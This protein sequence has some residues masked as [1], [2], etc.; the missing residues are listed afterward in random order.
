MRYGRPVRL[1]LDG[2]RR[3]VWTTA[4]TVQ[5]ALEELG[6]RAEGAYVSTSRSRRIG[7]EG[8]ALDVRTERTVTVMADGRARTVRTN[9]A[10]VRGGRRAGRDHAAAAGHH[11]GPGGQFPARRADR[12]GAADHRRRRKSARSR[13][14]SE[15]RAD[16]GPLRVQGHGGRR[17][18]GS[19]R[20]AADHV[21]PAHRQ[22]RQAEAAADQD[23]G[24]ARA[25][26]ADREGRHQADAHLRAGRRPAGL[27]GPRG[28]RVRRAAERAWTPRG[29]TAG[30]TSS[31]PGPGRASAARAAPR[32]HRRRNRRSGRRS[33]T[34][35]AG[36]ARGRTAGPGCTDEASTRTAVRCPREQPLPR[37]PP[38]P[39]RHPRTRGRPRRTPHQAAR[40]ELRDRREHGPPDRPHRRVRPDD[41][42]VEV[43]PA[44]ARSPSPC[45]RR[46]TAS[47]P[48]R[49]TTSWRPRCPPP[50]PRAC[51]TAPDRFALV[52]SRRHAGHRAAGPRARPRWSPTCRTTSPYRCCCTC[53]T[54]SRASSA[55]SSWS[56]PRSP[57]GSPRRPARRCT[58]SRP[59][60]PTGTP[61]SSGPVPIGRNV[62]WPAPNVDSGLVALTRRT[63]PV[64]TTAV[65]AR[66][67]RRRRRGVRPAAQ[68]PAGR[69]RRVGGFG[70][71][72]RGRPSS[73]PG[74]RRR[75]AASRSPSRS[76]RASR[77]TSE[78]VP[79]KQ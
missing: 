54:P 39:R 53:S 2:Q 71:R 14:R 24:G 59:S 1:T 72:R 29:R 65:Q 67:V 20:P 76:S 52:H 69:A 79:G 21:L 22:R 18:G 17:A 60:R 66:G 62:F 50:S 55:P 28:L 44:S 64:K 42:V 12:H 36:R 34:Y 9:A 8:L 26:G 63:E 7:R 48:S 77:R 47:S 31:T 74:S 45:W 43:G 37:R 35:G 61:R 16:G 56:R 10:T 4:H 51:R 57:T 25:P 11:L 73:R 40:P 49:S 6:V 46:P 23:R 32:T 33:C 15:M 78:P 30:S 13:S 27:A 68:D 58:A 38:R 19:A 70:G 41:V 5:G 75:P 3:E